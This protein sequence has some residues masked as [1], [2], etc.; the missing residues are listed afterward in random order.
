MAYISKGLQYTILIDSEIKLE[1]AITGRTIFI[2][3]VEDIY[4]DMPFNY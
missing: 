4:G 3:E 2:K 1:E